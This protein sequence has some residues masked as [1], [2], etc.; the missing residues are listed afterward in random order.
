MIDMN[1]DAVQHA[2]LNIQCEKDIEALRQK[3][4]FWRLVAA[5]LALLVFGMAISF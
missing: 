5:M 1:D 4:V 3:V 2:L